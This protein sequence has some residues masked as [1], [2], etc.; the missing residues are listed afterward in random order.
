VVSSEKTQKAWI[1]KGRGET[2]PLF[3]CSKK[4]TKGVI[5]GNLVVT[6]SL[7]GGKLNKQPEAEAQSH[8][9]E[10]LG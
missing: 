2:L 7:K 10:T 3:A 8:L 6:V 9:Q 4:S 5:K 1:R